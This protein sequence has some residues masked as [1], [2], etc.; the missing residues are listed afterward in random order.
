MKKEVLDTI[1]ILLAELI[2]TAL[3]V[4]LGCMGCVTGVGFK[5]THLI[6]CLN[7]GLVVMMIVQIF[8]VVSGSHI[9]P[10]VTAAAWVY[11]LL[12]T[13]MALA[14]VAAQ[15]IGGFM[16]YGA[17]KLLTPAAMFTESLE[18][19]AGFCVT[20]PHANI[21]L[22]QA[23]AVEFLATGVL[24]L[25]VCGV[26]DPRNAKHHDSVAIKFGL[27]IAT[28][29]LL[30]GPY[31]GASMNPARSLGPVLWNGNWKDH[32]VY[33]VGPLGGSFCCS[34]MYKLV[35]R[36]EVPQPP[37]ATQSELTSLNTEK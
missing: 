33:W 23:V 28:L 37:P 31:T 19:G 10:T 32:W 9:N 20:Q 6:I 1:A 34:F 7:F 25:V 8:G 11:E 15:I 35:F 18:K 5:P 12:S 24:I 30:S 29:A 16:G 17:L 36:R 26:W 13:K 27:T 2:G 21:N 14:Y 3:L 4:L 22:A